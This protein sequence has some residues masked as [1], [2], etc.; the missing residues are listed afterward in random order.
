MQ[1][2]EA[3]LDAVNGVIAALN[4]QIATGMSWAEIGRL[5]DDERAKGAPLAQLI[6]SLNLAEGT[7]TL[8]LND[9]LAVDSD[10][11][12]RSDA[13]SDSDTASPDAS[14]GASATASEAQASTASNSEREGSAK[15]ATG[16]KQNGKGGMQRAPRVRIQI[17]LSVNAYTNAK[18]VYNASN[19]VSSPVGVCA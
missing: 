18:C 19:N 16:A 3:N 4:A 14:K 11:S 7:A 12:S 9:W 2:I 13:G 17:D 15:R 6:A 1:V 5:I 8:L 10:E